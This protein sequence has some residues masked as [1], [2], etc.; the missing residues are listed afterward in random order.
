MKIALISPQSTFLGNNKKLSEFWSGSEYTKTYRAEWSGL[1]VALCIVAALTPMKHEV[2]I[3]DENVEQIDFTKHYD[4]VGITCIT[5]QATRAYEI[6]D[7]WRKRSV[8]VVLGG[9]HVSI[10]PEEAKNHADSVVIGEAENIWAQLLTDFENNRLKDFYKSDETADISLSPIPRYDLLKNKNYNLHWI[11]TTRGCPFDCV[12]CAASKVYGYKFRTKKIDQIIKEIEV[13][14]DLYPDSR[15]SFADDNMFINR[16]FSKDLLNRMISYN[17]RYMAQTDISIAKDDELLKLI[18]KS[19][20]TFLLMGFESLSEDNL[21][22]INK[23][24]KKLKYFKLLPEYI[25]QVQSNGIGI[26][27]SFIVGLKNDRFN[28]FDRITDFVTKNNLY[29]TQLSI[30]TPFPGTVVRSELI[31]E[32]RV[33]NTKWENYTGYDVNFIHQHISKEQFENGMVKSYR[34]LHSKEFYLQ[35]MIYFKKIHSELIKL[36]S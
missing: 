28:T 6:A 23:N 9:I 18:K 13:I 14:K 25:K 3:I 2:E 19:G 1:S 15:I 31:S 8:K 29:N 34:I 17:L 5:Q 21:E 11:Q 7:E 35:K 24:N 4:I 20:C 10:L 33:L 36:E 30:L 26:M 12:F 27:G 22:N 16:K 32:K